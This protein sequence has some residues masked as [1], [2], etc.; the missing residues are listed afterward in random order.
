MSKNTVQ[1]YLFLRS[2]NFL[3]I[4]L[5]FELLEDTSQNIN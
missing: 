3:W 2:N 1:P 5:I 4:N